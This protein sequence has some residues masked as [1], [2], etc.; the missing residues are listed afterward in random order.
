VKWCFSG[1]YSAG[2]TLYTLV[3]VYKETVKRFSPTSGGENALLVKISRP[4]AWKF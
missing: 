3:S 1:A 2:K 4:S